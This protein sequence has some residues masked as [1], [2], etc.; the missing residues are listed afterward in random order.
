MN[1]SVQEFC[2]SVSSWRSYGQK[3]I[4]PFFSSQCRVNRYSD[5]DVSVYAARL[6]RNDLELESFDFRRLPLAH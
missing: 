3:F 4:V 5:V 6:C 2:E 1:L